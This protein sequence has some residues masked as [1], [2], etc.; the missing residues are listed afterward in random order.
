MPQNSPS[1]SV[2]KSTDTIDLGRSIALLF[3]HKWLIVAVTF[4][5]MVVG[6]VYALLATPIYRAD[7]LLQVEQLSPSN[8]FSDRGSIIGGEPSSRSEIQIL[9]SRMVLGRAVDILSLDMLI[10]PARLPIVG[11]F[12]NRIGI[13]RPDFAQ[14]WGYTWAGETITVGAMPVDD[15]YLGKTFT[16]RVLDSERYSL[17]YDGKSLG[18]AKV[19]KEAEFLG[20]DIVLDIETINAPRGAAFSLSRIQPRLAIA[21]V[22]EQLNISEQGKETGILQLQ[23]T[24]ADPQLAKSALRTIVDIYVAQNIQHQAEEARKSLDF[25]STQ[26]PAVRAEM[27][28]AEDQLNAY[29]VD[30]ESVDLSLETQSVLERLVNIEAKLNELKFSEAEIS[31]RFTPSHP[32][33]AALLDKK[34]QL[35]SERAGIDSKI[36]RLPE[37]Q[38]EILR[39]QRDA[40]VNQEIYMQL[41]NKMQEMQIAEASTVGNVRVLDDAEV[42]PSPVEPRKV[43]LLVVATLL[44]GLVAAG[45]VLVRGMFTRGVKTL[46]QIEALGL[47][48]FATVP[49]SEEQEKRNRRDRKRTAEAGIL[50][51]RNPA[52]LSVEALRALRT[53]VHFSMINSDNN[54]VMITG[55]SPAVGK[56]F[57]AVNLAVLCAQM[58]KRVLI[59]DGDMRKGQIHSMF[60]QPAEGGLSEVLAGQ[61][62]LVDVVRPVNEIESLH[63][64]SR[65][66]APP[67]PSELLATPALSELLKVV[68]LRYD[69]VIIDSPPVL[70]V[71]DAAL[72]GKQVKTTLMVVRFQ[73]NTPK[74]I[75]IAIHR[76]GMAGVQVTGAVL[77]AIERKV[78]G[79]YGYF[80]YSYK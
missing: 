5:F 54:C 25:L 70:A 69:L 26:L 44:G 33:Y 59:I 31:R 30:R 28:S 22:K 65:G 17:S 23:L 67:N 61:Q 19:G 24:D 56:S 75:G 68:N 47:P 46:D 74:E 48:V 62:P 29:R 10:E 36:D 42:Y 27:I 49:L 37:T 18:E 35:Q 13:K 71:T 3:E 6:V 66:V 79:A 77:N 72:I 52:A 14:G 78:A 58:G 20:G 50:A 73:F 60:R 41:R 1:T 32:T 63:Y 21:N 45:M 8:P 12:L 51:L 15:A 9:G 39:L 64:I 11:G 40:S 16:L 2:T 53:S 7:A 80:A 43:F 57:V 76:M 34:N 55:P 4:L 38:Q